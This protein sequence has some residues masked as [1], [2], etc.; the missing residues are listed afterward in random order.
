MRARD[1]ILVFAFVFALGCAGPAAQRD[2]ST[3]SAPATTNAPADATN[4]AFVYVGLASGGIA[5]F[6]LDAETGAL[7]RRGTVPA[8]RAPTSLCRS[9]EREALIAVDE[10]SGQAASF[11]INAKNGALTSVGRASMGGALPSGATLD[12]TGKYLIAALPRAGRVSVVAI[13]PNGGL[14]PIDTF[15]AGV[16][17]HAVA[18]HPSMQVAFVSNFRAGSVSQYTFNVGTGMLTPK[19]GPPLALPTG[20]GPT[21]LV[22][23]PSGHWVYLLDEG[24]DSIAV[25]AFDEDVKALSPIS[26]Q[27]VSTLRQGVARG[28]SRPADLAVSPTGRFLYATNRGP[29]DVAAFAIEPGGTLELVGRESSGGRAPGALAVDPSGRI[30]IVANEG[31]K[32]LGVFHIDPTTGALGGRRIVQLDAAPLSVLALRP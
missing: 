26:L 19:A 15:A 14:A 24:T 10:T 21:R 18:I 1:P 28:K 25:H 23:H 32:S 27:I 20:S 29:D 9:V 30:L 22:S 31:G 17:A 16:G 2:P 5:L 11:S 7:A 13:T 4:R 12:D 8:G 3:A 6:H